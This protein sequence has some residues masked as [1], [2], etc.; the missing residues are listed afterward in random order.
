MIVQA[1]Q[2][3]AWRDGIIEDPPPASEIGKMGGGL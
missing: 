3:Q 1:N 2:R